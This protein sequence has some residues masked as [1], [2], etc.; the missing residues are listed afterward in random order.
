MVPE[1]ELRAVDSLIVPLNSLHTDVYFRG[2]CVVGVVRVTCVLFY[3]IIKNIYVRVKVKY[4]L[5]L[6]RVRRCSS[7]SAPRIW[8]TRGDH[9]QG[10]PPTGII[11]M[12]LHQSLRLLFR[13]NNPVP[14]T[15]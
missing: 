6:Y 8:L 9:G 5:L 1:D 2:S 4:P 15:L 3:I 14:A 10:G 7:S 13:V 11:A 12:N